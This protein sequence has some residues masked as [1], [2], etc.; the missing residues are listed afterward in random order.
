MKSQ[1]TRNCVLKQ[2]ALARRRRIEAL[3]CLPMA[4]IIAIVYSHLAAELFGL[5]GK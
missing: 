3:F 2:Q 1:A 5:L 4:I